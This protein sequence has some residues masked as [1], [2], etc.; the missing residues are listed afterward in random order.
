MIW[1]DI[2]KTLMVF[3]AGL[4]AGRL[5]RPFAGWALTRLARPFGGQPAAVRR[6]SRPCG[7]LIMCAAWHFGLKLA[8]A[9]P[10]WQ[11]FLVKPMLAVLG[12]G[13][14]MIGWQLL[15]ILESYFQKLFSAKEK[16][17]LHKHFLPYG[18]KVLKIAAAIVVALFILQNAGFNITSLLASLGIGGIAVALGARETL[19]NLFGGI[20]IVAD[21]PFAAGDWI[22]C[23][24]IEGTVQDIG[25]RSTKVKTFYDSVITIP[26]AAIADSTVD[27][28]GRRSAR[29]TRFTLSLNFK[30]SPEEMEA[31]VEGI[32]NILLSNSHSRKDYF[33]VYFFRPWRVGAGGFCEFLFKS[34]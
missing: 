12:F 1:G 4:A 23:S 26:N 31:F 32:R 8:G 7:I 24:G 27:N 17:T 5:S 2:L 20:V 22:L 25:F 3:A 11:A 6:L 13:L 34:L 30:T 21:K 16:D 9:P 10:E 28:L 14:I 29:R 19:R 33:Q 15:D 18:K